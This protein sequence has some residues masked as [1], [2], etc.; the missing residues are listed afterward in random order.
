MTLADYTILEND[1]STDLFQTDASYRHVSALLDVLHS[2]H[3][4]QGKEKVPTFTQ[5]LETQT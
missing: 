4:D 3:L 2:F 5:F 1:I